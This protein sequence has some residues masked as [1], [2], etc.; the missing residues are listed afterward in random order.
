[1]THKIFD[2]KGTTTGYIAYFVNTDSKY[3]YHLWSYFKTYNP[4][5]GF[6]TD[7]ELVGKYENRL[8]LANG[9]NEIITKDRL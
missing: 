5:E 1:M 7:S 8:A 3:P 9:I 2:L 6:V 4:S